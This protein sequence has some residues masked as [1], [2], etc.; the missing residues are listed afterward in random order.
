MWCLEQFQENTALR[1]EGGRTL[2][3][4]MLSEETKR[5]AE[6]V[7]GRKLVF[8]LCRNTIGSVLGYVAFLNGQ[9]PPVLLSSHLE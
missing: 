3:Y 6:A 2:T 5:I 9:I 7:G 1:E 4:G 8:S